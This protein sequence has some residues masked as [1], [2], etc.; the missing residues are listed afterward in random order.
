MSRTTIRMRVLPRFPAR[1][2][3]TNGIKTVRDGADMIV[4]NDFS[5]LNR[6]PSIDDPTKLFLLTWNVDQNS[7]SIMSFTDTFAAAIDVTGLMS[8]S[9]YD[10]NA[11]HADAFNRANHTGTQAISTVASLQA[12]LDTLTAAAAAKLPLAGGT[13]TGPILDL[14][15]APSSA[16]TK[17]AQFD[18]SAVA[19][20][21]TRSVGVPDRN[22][23]L[24][25]SYGSP[26]TLPNLGTIDLTGIPAGVRRVTALF[27]DVS[28]NGTA[29]LIAQLIGGGSPDGA[30]YA[31]TYKVFS[32]SAAAAVPGST[33]GFALANPVNAA[34]Q[35]SGK[36]VLELADPSTNT[37][38]ISGDLSDAVNTRQNGPVGRKTLTGVLSGIRLS[39]LG[40]DLY[41]GG[42]VL[43][44]WEF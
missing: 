17:K 23:T 5:D 21:F 9:V 24:G 20:G 37:W 32:T 35:F 40:S 28:T 31:S 8:A 10:P 27:T 26:V 16:P 12:A 38:V 18:T 7:Y 44:T 29:I 6:V 11:R 3:G 39:T 30:G 41:D 4:K 33:L 25:I 22:I 14:V 43:V 19:A 1:I 42:K 34:A 2:S 13:M 15:V 36:I